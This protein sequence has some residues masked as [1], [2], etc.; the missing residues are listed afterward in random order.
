MA[1]RHYLKFTG[2]PGEVRVTVDLTT[3]NT[4]GCLWVSLYDQDANQLGGVKTGILLSGE[5][6]RNVG[7]ILLGNRKDVTVE[8]GLDQGMATSTPAPIGSKYLIRFDDATQ[9]P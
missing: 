1:N 7:R 3:A 4:I 2:A 6:S 5:N 9:T 8:I